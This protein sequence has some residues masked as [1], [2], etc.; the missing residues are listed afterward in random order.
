MLR[1]LVI[2]GVAGCGKSS[3]GAAAAQALGLPLIEGDV[4][5]SAGNLAKMSAGIALDDAD[6]RGWLAALGREL[7][8]HPHGAV[9]TCSALKRAYRDQLRAACP[10]LRFAFLAIGRDEA[11]A[12]VAGRGATHFFSVDLVASQFDALEPPLDEPGV[13]TLQATE[14]I[15]ALSRAIHHWLDAKETA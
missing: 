7:Q 8:A 13:L 12:R 9:L 14:P 2:M 10:G 4:F 3:V 11:Q 15:E 6:R 1:H 5:H